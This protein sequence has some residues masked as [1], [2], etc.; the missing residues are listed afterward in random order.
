MFTGIID[1]CGEVFEVQHA[2]NQSRAMIKTKF[3]DLQLGESIA[4]NGACM[5]V[6]VIK[7]N[8]F[9]C[10][11]SP[12][13]L[14]LTTLGLMQKGDLINLERSLR[15]NDRLGGHFV[16]GHVEQIAFVKDKIIH[17]DFLEYEFAGILAAAQQYLVKKGSIAVN[18]VSLTINEVNAGSFRV[19]LVPHTLERTNLSLLMLGDKVNIEYDMLAKLVSTQIE[20]LI[21]QRMKVMA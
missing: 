11:I 16:S 17:Q 4:L 6:A 5:T 15:A 3:S 8:I 13:S 10:D 21:L 1:H 20:N 9:S 18:G 7:D 14:K 19:M 12:D 2:A